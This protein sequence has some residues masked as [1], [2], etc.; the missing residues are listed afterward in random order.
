MLNSASLFPAAACLAAVSNACSRLL[1]SPQRALLYEGLWGRT[2]KHSNNT[3]SQESRVRWDL[4][5][6]LAEGSL[7]KAGCRGPG[8]QTSA[9][10]ELSLTTRYLAPLLAPG[11]VLVH[12]PHTGSP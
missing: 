10:L 4:V 6:G 3:H 7:A 11:L 12:S 1:A 2:R 9:S 8:L 5:A